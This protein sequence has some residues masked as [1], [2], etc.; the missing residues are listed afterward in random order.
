M[1]D[2]A[3]GHQK[4]VC[5]GGSVR[6]RPARKEAVTVTEESLSIRGDYDEQH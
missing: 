4:S 6:E 5:R 2:V 1:P 3:I